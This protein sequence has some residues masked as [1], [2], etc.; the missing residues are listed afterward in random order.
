MTGVEKIFWPILLIGIL[1]FCISYFR[2]RD[3]IPFEKRE[4]AEKVLIVLLLLALLTDVGFA[5]NARRI[6]AAEI[7]DCIRFYRYF[8]SETRDS[9]FYFVKEKCFDYFTEEEIQELRASG[10]EW[11]KRQLATNFLSNLDLGYLN[12]E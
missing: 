6:Q 3:K 1:V 5:I 2:M 8:P 9:E 4:R 10:Y 7:N 12:G 11:Q